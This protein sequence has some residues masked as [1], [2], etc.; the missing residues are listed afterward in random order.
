MSRLL[1][2]VIRLQRDTERQLTILYQ[3]NV[4]G[5]LS[6]SEFVTLAAVLLERARMRGMT[7]ADLSLAAQV[8]QAL[9]RVEAPLGLMPT[10]KDLP[11]LEK[12][13]VTVLTASVEVEKP[14][15]LIASRAARLARLGRD[16]PADAATWGMTVGMRERGIEGW[17]REPSPK[18]CPICQAWADGKVRSPEV[19]MA[20]HTGCGCIQRVAV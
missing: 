11:G 6:E 7:L 9:G 13:V 2:G 3:R 10:D 15:E 20:R 14:E 17:V 1:D 8:S 18:A 4:E 19:V 16:A 5:T 12:A